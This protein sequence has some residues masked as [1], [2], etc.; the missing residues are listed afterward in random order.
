[1]KWASDKQAKNR[2]AAVEMR[3]LEGIRTR[4]PGNEQVLKALADLYTR[5]GHIE[6]GLEADR[7]LV[8]LC[9]QESEVWYN[10]GCSCALAGRKDDAFHALARAVELGYHD[11]EWLQQDHD[12]NSIRDDPRYQQLME[13]LE[14]GAGKTS[15]NN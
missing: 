13:Q 3:F 14:K 7:R 8:E 15:S 6:K 4:C 5:H 9:P 2:A 1:M 11:Y 10:Y 12:L